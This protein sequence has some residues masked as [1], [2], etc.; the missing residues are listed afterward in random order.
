M[1]KKLNDRLEIIE[2][3][4]QEIL[5]ADYT[6]LN[7]EDFIKQIKQNKVDI[8][9]HA[10]QSGEKSILLLTD[11]TGTLLL[12]DVQNAF[13][14]L[15]PAIDPYIKAGA[16]VGMT[17]FK[18]FALDLLNRVASVPRRTFNTVDEAKSWLSAQ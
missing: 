9:R 12:E 7:Q 3:R 2:H 16:I 5:F 14:D 10:E 1:G 13:R 15:V 4:G 18:K 11:L 8:L 6:G 17:G